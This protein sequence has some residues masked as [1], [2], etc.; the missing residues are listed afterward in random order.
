MNNIDANLTDAT[1]EKLRSIIHKNTGITIGES[2]KTMIVSR[3]RSR[4]RETN[5]ASFHDYVERLQTDPRE[6]Q[7]LINRVTTNK[8]Y[9]YRTPRVWEHFEQVAV[10]HFAAKGLP[11]PMRIWSGAASTG[12]EAHTIGMVLE[13]RR[14]LGNG[15]DY[16]VLGTDV[17]SRVLELAEDGVYGPT[18]LREILKARPE[19]VAAHM[20]G[21]DNAGYK[22]SKEIKSR[23]TFKLHNLQKPLMGA[24]SFD[25][26]FLR[27]VLIYFTKPDQEAILRLVGNVLEPDGTLIIGESE[28]LTQL[29]L[30][31]E[32]VSPMVYQKSAYLRANEA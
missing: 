20:T 4:L 22:V 18:A 26:V 6:M 13:G 21:D 9:C 31:F 12:E 28:T 5:D 2:R 3:L 27:N 17:S 7:E 32:L 8:T 24:K 30:D 16:A 19:L 29:D 23:L 14:R 1:F 15:F 11:R 10:P 25:V